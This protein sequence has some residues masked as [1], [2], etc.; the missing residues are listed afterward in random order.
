M[1]LF[2]TNISNNDLHE[3]FHYFE[4]NDKKSKT[5][6]ESIKTILNRESK[7]HGRKSAE[8]TLIKDLKNTDMNEIAMY[9]GI[10][11][12]RSNLKPKWTVSEVKDI[13]MSKK[14][15]SDELVPLLQKDYLADKNI[16]DVEAKKLAIKVVDDILTNER[17]TIT[18]IRNMIANQKRGKDTIF[19]HEFNKQRLNNVRNAILLALK[20]LKES[21]EDFVLSDYLNYD[22][23]G[24]VMTY[25]FINKLLGLNYRSETKSLLAELT[26]VLSSLNKLRDSGEIDNENGIKKLGEWINNIKRCLNVFNKA[27]TKTIIWPEA[28][29][30]ITDASSLKRYFDQLELEREKAYKVIRQYKKRSKGQTHVPTGDEAVDTAEAASQW[31]DEKLNQAVNKLVKNILGGREYKMMNQV[32]VVSEADELAQQMLDKMEGLKEFLQEDHPD[33]LG[34]LSSRIATRMMSNKALMGR[35]KKINPE[36]S[37]QME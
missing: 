15:I 10:A 16:T 31:N 34:E 14:F 20:T 25:Q 22:V 11:L 18:N 17:D 35:P 2:D 3:V 24:N 9:I 8:Y 13:L 23:N 28:N 1:G 21:T 30:S 4:A 32:E 37:E 5:K 6:L 33:F 7:K 27:T 29:E 19:A 12:V 36:E 26:V